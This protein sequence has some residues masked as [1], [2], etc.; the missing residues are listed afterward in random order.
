MELPVEK[1][2]DQTAPADKED[3][4]IIEDNLEG[5]AKKILTNIPIATIIIITIGIFKQILYYQNFDLAIKYY[6]GFSEIGVIV[7]DDLLY[8]LSFL[9]VMSIFPYLNWS[10][11]SALGERKEMEKWHSDLRVKL[12]TEKA[13]KEY[14]NK[15]MFSTKRDKII[16]TIFIIAIGTTIYEA[17]TII[18]WNYSKYLILAAYISF[19]FSLF[20]N[21]HFPDRLFPN[22]PNTAFYILL[23]FFCIVCK[24]G[25]DIDAVDNGRFKNTIIR[26][27]DTTYISSDTSYFIGKTDKYYFVYNTKD[28][29]TIVIPSETVKSAKIRDRGLSSSK[30]LSNK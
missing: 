28:T 5:P 23:L 9:L 19:M 24:T 20:I 4:I 6:L 18:S 14:I 12:K 10:K 27:T 21:L 7:S 22:Y 1:T 8:I 15:G 2:A 13:Y 29:T 30:I 3:E 11:N 16:L 26:T 25:L 17:M